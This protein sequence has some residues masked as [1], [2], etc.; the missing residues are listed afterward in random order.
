MLQLQNQVFKQEEEDS[1][2]SSFKS[3]IVWLQVLQ[4]QNTKLV[5]PAVLQ[6]R[7]T[8]P[9]LQTCA[10][11]WTTNIDGLCSWFTL[12]FGHFGGRFFHNSAD[13]QRWKNLSG[14]F[15]S[16][17]T[18]PDVNDV[19]VCCLSVD[20][21]CKEGLY[22]RLVF[23]CSVRCQKCCSYRSELH[24]HVLHHV[25]GLWLTPENQNDAKET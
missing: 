8:P 16:C 13:K 7:A 6:P 4:G 5:N 18:W 23:V 17:F 21:C 14:V 3:N 11:W 10:L 12:K 24:V 2:I 1:V 22:T 25:I 19:G 9:L 15:L 20:K